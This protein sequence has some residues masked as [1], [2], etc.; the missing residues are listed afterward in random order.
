MVLIHMIKMVNRSST[1]DLM[2]SYD[3][4]AVI[5]AI[6]DSA[7]ALHDSDSS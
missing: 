3:V 7:Q 4:E 1:D 6:S 2:L 5:K